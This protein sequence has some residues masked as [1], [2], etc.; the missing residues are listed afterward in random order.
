VGALLVGLLP[1]HAIMSIDVLTAIFAIVPLL[2]IAIP[3]PARPEMAS[4]VTPASLWTDVRGGLRYVWDWPGMRL[5]V[6]LAM[7]VN[8]MANPT[9]ALTPILVTEY[10]QGGALQLGWIDLAFGLGM[11][12]GGLLLGVWGGCKRRTLMIPLGFVGFAVG[13]LLIGLSP[14]SAF[15]LALTGMGIFGAMSSVLNGTLMAIMQST[16]APEMQGRVFTAL[17]SGASAMTPLAFLLAGP[18]GETFGPQPW[19]VLTGVVVLL[20]RVST[21]FIPTIMRLD[22][23]KPAARQ[24]ANLDAGE[25]RQKNRCAGQLR[26]HGSLEGCQTPTD[27]R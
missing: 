20:C 4:A 25:Q 27:D 6:L 26:W 23:Q 14:A 5:L 16:V 2:L 9:I 13:S 18:F 1:F 11:L 10:F 8:F 21:F 17:N 22:E 7:L 12:G 24:A 19:F 3:Q 15:W